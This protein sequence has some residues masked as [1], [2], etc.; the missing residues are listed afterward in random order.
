M[1]CDK[2]KMIKNL[3]IKN[4]TLILLI[5]CAIFT[6]LSYLNMH[7]IFYAFTIYFISNI[8]FMVDYKKAIRR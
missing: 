8:S 4:V 1:V 2:I 6:F 5:L 7:F 3:L